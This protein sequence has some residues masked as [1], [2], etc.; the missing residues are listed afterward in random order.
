LSVAAYDLDAIVAIDVHTHAERSAEHEQD[1]V[2]GELLAAAS[3][4]FGS[5]PAQPT[6]Q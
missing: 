2:A 3:R 4:Y 1:P 5:D 6:T